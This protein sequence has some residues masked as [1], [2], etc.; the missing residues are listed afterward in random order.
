MPVIVKTLCNT[1]RRI[2]FWRDC[3]EC[4]GEQES[5]TLW[6]EH[7]GL[8]FVWHC[9]ECHRCDEIEKGCLRDILKRS[10]FREMQEGRMTP[11]PR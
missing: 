6:G 9:L 10:G 2:S 5:N 11:D 3:P 4:G 8:W 1:S 7:V